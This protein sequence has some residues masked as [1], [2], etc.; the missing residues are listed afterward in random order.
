MLQDAVV[1]IV[2]EGCLGDLLPAIHRAGMGYLA[3]VASPARG[4]LRDQLQ[5]AGIPA[6][7]AP[8]EVVESQQI[9]FLQAGGRSRMTAQLL[10]EQSVPQVW[11]VN[12]L[13]AWLPVDDEVISA[14]T[15]PVPAPMP[16]Q[17]VPGRHPIPPTVS[18]APDSDADSSPVY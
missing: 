14:Q 5:R 8:P 2:P 4:P 13:G 17:N 7:Q 6:T 10:L 1:A 3:R 15:I 11:I 12:T 9:I 16:T 18:S